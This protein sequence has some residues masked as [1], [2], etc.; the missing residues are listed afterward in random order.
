MHVR[1]GGGAPLALGHRTAPSHRR[2]PAV[3]V[4]TMTKVSTAVASSHLSNLF[5]PDGL[6]DCEDPECCWSEEC[7][8]NQYCSSAPD[9]ASILLKAATTTSPFDTFFERHKF[10]VLPGSLQKFAKINKF[11]PR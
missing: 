3:M 1:R 2:L 4:L 9:P 10:L 5:L 8:G 6:T 7:V 11:D